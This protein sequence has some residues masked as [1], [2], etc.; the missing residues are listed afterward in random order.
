MCKALFLKTSS[1]GSLPITLNVCFE[2]KLLSNIEAKKF[3]VQI[4]I[5]SRTEN[6]QILNISNKFNRASEKKRLIQNKSNTE[7]IL[8]DLQT[9]YHQDY[10]II[11]NIMI[12]IYLKTVVIFQCYCF[13]LF[14]TTI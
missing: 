8:H 14:K 11:E 3:N 10:D 7:I 13:K 6:W 9:Q 12:E 1:N 2:I 4:F 5:Y